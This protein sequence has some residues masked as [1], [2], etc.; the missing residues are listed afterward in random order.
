MPD[1]TAVQARLTSESEA[2]AIQEKLKAVYR[3]AKEVSGLIGRYQGGAD[4]V[5]NAAVDSIFSAGERG[6]IAQMITACNTLTAAWEGDAEKS[7]LLGL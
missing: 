5:F 6:E 7:A 4:T 1:Y 2:A 3:Q